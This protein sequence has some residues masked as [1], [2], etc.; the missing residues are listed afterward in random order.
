MKRPLLILLGF[1]ILGIIQSMNLLFIDFFLIIILTVFIYKIYKW[2]IIFIF[3]CFSILGFILFNQNIAGNRLPSNFIDSAIQI[4]GIVKDIDYTSTNRQKIILKTNSFE[5]NNFKIDK[6]L[7]IQAILDLDENVEYNQIIRLS[8][9]LQNFDFARNPG[10]F[11]ENLYMKTKGVDYKIFAKLIKKY[12]I[13]NDFDLAIYLLHQKLN[14]V[15][16]SILPKKEASVLK[17]ML[18][19]DKKNLDSSVEQI[20][21]DAG[22]SHILAISGLHISIFSAILFSIFKHFKLNKK[23]NSICILIILILYCIFTGNSVSTVRAVIMIGIVL[24]GFILYRESDIYTSIFTA[25]FILLIYQPLY[26]FNIGFQLSFSAVIGILILTPI[27]SRIQIYPKFIKAYLMPSLAASLATFPIIAYHF[28][29]ISIVSVIIN[30]FILPFVFIIVCIGLLCGII[31]LF[32][33]PIAKFLCG[34]VYFILITYEKLCTIGS[35]LIPKA[36]IGQPNIWLIIIYYIIILSIAYYYYNPKQAR[37]NLKKYLISLLSI[38]ILISCLIIFKPKAL[39]IVYLDVNQGDCIVIHTK[40]N[41]NFLIDGGGYINRELNEP[42][43]GSQIVLPYLNYKG[44]KYLDLVF[45][46]HPDGDHILGIIELIDYIKI[47]QIVVSNNIQQNELLKI[48][49]AKANKKSIPI[50]KMGSININQDLSF[51]C[52]HP[53]QNDYI[54]S[55]NNNSLVIYMKYKNNTF[56]FTGDIEKEA[57]NNIIN[58]Y[59]FNIDVLKVPHHGSK[60]S[61]TQDFL[62]ILKPKLSIISCGRNNYYNHPASE[63]L[64]R[65]KS[66]NSQILNTAKEGAIILKTDGNTIKITTMYERSNLNESIKRAD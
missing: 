31:G 17:A 55:T 36:L 23:I 53:N 1:Y 28:Y 42:N 26:I 65:Y 27:L 58:N 62:N 11:N 34:I 61:S 10:G 9:K 66:I 24:A 22:I 35:N 18:L 13:V 54:Y 19:G 7:N 5:L 21:R 51:E 30:I 2:N 57:E 38:C 12:N 39:E 8:G 3:P 41:K 14:Y 50:I 32:S 60:T 16:D 52:I 56:L 44:I 15:Y 45:I 4:V 49:E 37:K 20:Y 64:Q 25:A 33:I 63:V 48:L 59:N 43:T 40:D 29:T 46:S 6:Q 47:N